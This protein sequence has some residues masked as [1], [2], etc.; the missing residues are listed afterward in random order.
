MDMAVPIADAYDLEKL[1]PGSGLVVYDGG[2]HYAYLERFEQTIRVLQSF[3]GGE[4]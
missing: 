3:L 2:T 1:I 4:K